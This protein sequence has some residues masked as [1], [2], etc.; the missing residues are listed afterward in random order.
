M[1]TCDG[2]PLDAA[3]QP[4]RITFWNNAL[5]AFGLTNSSTAA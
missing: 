1:S 2:V 3:A 4:D 5:A